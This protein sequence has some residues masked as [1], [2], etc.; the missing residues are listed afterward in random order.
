MHGKIDFSVQEDISNR[1]CPHCTTPLQTVNLYTDGSVQIERCQKCYGLF[2][3]PGEIETVL[4]N[5]VSGANIINRKLLT[6]ITQERSQHWQKIRYLKCPVCQQF[7]RRINFG[8][9]SG[10]V[11]DQCRT[12]GIWLDNGEISHLMEWKKAGGQILHEKKQ[13]QLKRQQSRP[14][15]NHS[16]VEISESFNHTDDDNLLGTVARLIFQLMR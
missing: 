6:A 4:E 2:F 12:H 3:D 14:K 11:I 15:S 8:Y 5:S 9:R 16:S 1:V 10:V 13:A 7:M